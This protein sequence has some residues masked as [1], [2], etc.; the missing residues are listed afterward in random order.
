[1]C[2]NVKNCSLSSYMNILSLSFNRNDLAWLNLNKLVILDLTTTGITVN[3]YR[4]MLQCF[5]SKE[6]N[7]A[8]YST[9]MVSH[10]HGHKISEIINLK[11]FDIALQCSNGYMFLP[12]NII[13]GLY[14]YL[15]FIYTLHKYLYKSILF[16]G[17][18]KNTRPIL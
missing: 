18:K 16:I 15:A 4:Y 10:V 9:Y 3:I 12:V 2:W 11:Y 7:L 8:S 13:I 6:V 14:I 17:E 1:M 5:V